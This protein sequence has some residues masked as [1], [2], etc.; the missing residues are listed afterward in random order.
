MLTLFAKYFFYVQKQFIHQIGNH[1]ILI[2]CSQVKESDTL[3]LN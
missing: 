3:F 1:I 2:N